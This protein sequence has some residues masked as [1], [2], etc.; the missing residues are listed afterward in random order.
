ML[1]VPA[2]QWHDVRK[3]RKRQDRPAILCVLPVGHA[4]QQLSQG[5][6]PLMECRP[7]VGL[8][9]T[10]V[11]HDVIASGAADISAALPSHRIEEE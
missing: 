8:G 1:L 7:P 11:I 10:D 3:L 5:R 4:E 6:L 2:A 9:S